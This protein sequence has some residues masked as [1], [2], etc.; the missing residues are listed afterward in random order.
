MHTKARGWNS[1][2]T[3]EERDTNQESNITI[4]DLTAM[5]CISKYHDAMFNEITAGIKLNSR[6]EVFC[7][8]F[9]VNSVSRE[10]RYISPDRE[11]EDCA[12]SL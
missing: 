9:C 4:D 8:C 7:C 3:V 6:K 12:S 10:R 2:P 11:G 1:G 5:N